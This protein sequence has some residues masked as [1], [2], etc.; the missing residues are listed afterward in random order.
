MLKKLSIVISLSL[1]SGAAA[2]AD[3]GLVVSYA[4]GES[5]EFVLSQ[6]ARMAFEDGNLKIISDR[7]A[8][9]LISLATIARMN[10]SD[11][12]SIET[13]TPDVNDIAI[14]YDKVSETLTFSGLPKERHLYVS[15]A[16]TAAS[17]QTPGSAPEKSC[18]S[19]PCVPDYISSA[20]EPQPLSLSDNQFTTQANTTT[21]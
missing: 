21:T 13:V 19:A 17:S 8:P 11:K 16:L 20:P 7:E 14:T 4:G 10:F 12:V 2:F 9:R 1:W 5:D 15:G 3:N 6:I 18:R